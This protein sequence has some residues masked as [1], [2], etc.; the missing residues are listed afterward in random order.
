VGSLTFDATGLATP[1]LDEP[2]PPWPSAL[3]A[4]TVD[5]GVRRP[6]GGIASCAAQICLERSGSGL[7][8]P[9]F[10]A[11]GSF[12]TAQRRCVAFTLVL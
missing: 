10:G 2:P 8:D 4:A 1:D 5:A 6:D 7:V 12:V 9:G 11:G 3:D